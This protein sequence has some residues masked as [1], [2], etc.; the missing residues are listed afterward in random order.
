MVFK[1]HCQPEVEGCRLHLVIIHEACL[2]FEI[3][4]SQT[5]L[6]TEHVCIKYVSKVYNVHIH[7][8]SDSV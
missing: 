5:T 1:G 2:Y 6:Y 3:D 4:T 7:W 8:L